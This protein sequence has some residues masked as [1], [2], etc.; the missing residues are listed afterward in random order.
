ME[1][2]KQLAIY[3]NQHAIKHMHTPDQAEGFD[4]PAK[5][6]AGGCHNWRYAIAA[7]PDRLHTF[8]SIIDMARQL[9][10]R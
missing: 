7:T 10:G 5:D 2:F 8:L 6:S 1:G 4:K 9:R 3:S